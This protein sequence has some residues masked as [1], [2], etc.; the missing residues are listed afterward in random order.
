M[1]I[2]WMCLKNIPANSGDLWDNG[3]RPEP[4]ATRQHCQRPTC[5]PVVSQPPM[6][7]DLQMPSNLPATSESSRRSP[8][9]NNHTMSLAHSATTH[10]NSHSAAPGGFCRC[11]PCGQRPLLCLFTMPTEYYLHVSTFETILRARS[12]KV[13]DYLRKN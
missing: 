8:K 2:I 6:T 9:A 4:G 13:L 10:T 12:F 1:E 11:T 5:A 3:H 7:V